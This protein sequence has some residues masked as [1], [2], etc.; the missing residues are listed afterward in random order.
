MTNQDKKEGVDVIVEDLDGK[1]F[2]RFAGKSHKSFVEMAEDIGVELPCSCCSGACFVCAC[3][4]VSGIDDVDIATLSV[5][6]VDVDKDQVLACVGGIK[7]S[8]FSDGKYHKIVLKK[9]L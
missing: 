6:L 2:C 7:S 9:L 3:Q 4:I 8:C 1:E 5:P